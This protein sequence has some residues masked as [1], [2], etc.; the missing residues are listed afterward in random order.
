LRVILLGEST[1][2]GVGAASH[3][4]GLA[5]QFALAINR[6]IS[7]PVEWRVVARTG[8]NARKCLVELV[9]KIAGERADLVLIALGVNDTIEFHSARRWTVD[10]TRLIETVQKELGDP[11][12]VLSGVPPLQRFPLLPNPLRFILGARST[13]LEAATLASSKRM[14]RVVHVPFHVDEHESA[15]ELFCSDG[16][17]PSERGYQLWAEQL[18]AAFANY[19]ARER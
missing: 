10:V 7:R 13:S 3:E 15:D 18:A 1:A 4:A 12:V 16:F 6:A 14:R 17:H 8:I 9:P 2:A 5:G 11:L 19:D